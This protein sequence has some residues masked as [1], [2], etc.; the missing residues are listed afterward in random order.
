MLRCRF[1]LSHMIACLSGRSRTSSPLAAEPRPSAGSVESVRH[2]KQLEDM[3]RVVPLRGTHQATPSHQ[4]QSGAPTGAPYNLALPTIWRPQ[5]WRPHF[6]WR[7][8]RQ[9][10]PILFNCLH[11]LQRSDSLLTT[12]P[13]PSGCRVPSAMPRARSS[14]PQIGGS[15]WP[16][17]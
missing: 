15:S 17:P 7:Q 8:R 11:V 4:L 1:A 3:H 16:A 13:A 9:G 6:Y 12:R 2:R 5:Q 14:P 10:L